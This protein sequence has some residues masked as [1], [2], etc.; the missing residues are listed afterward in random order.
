MP[1][2]VDRYG[3]NAWF[4]TPGR[5]IYKSQERTVTRGPDGRPLKVEETRIRA[6]NKVTVIQQNQRTVGQGATKSSKASETK[7]NGTYTRA[8][9]QIAG[10]SVQVGGKVQEVR[11]QVGTAQTHAYVQG[12]H[13]R[14]SGDAFVDV[15]KDGFEAMLQLDVTANLVTG[16]ASITQDYH[17]KVNGENVTIRATVGADCK[18]G[19]QGRLA[20][21]VMM[22]DGKPGVV[23][24]PKGFVGARCDIS[25]KAQ[26]Y[27]NDPAKPVAEVE[28]A[29][30]FSAGAVA[31]AGLQ[32]RSNGFKAW[33][34]AAVG[35]G[36]GFELKA[37][38][39][40]PRM[41]WE[42]PGLLTNKF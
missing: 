28:S 6:T 39:D 21:G 26:V 41:I 23:F 7:D 31:D 3:S 16:G 25:A 38:L 20:I 29:L 12:P 1:P 27:I 30:V 32:V 14:M 17:M 40:V 11:G 13:L 42:T 35:A 19:A 8:R 4:F 9:G 22:I 24:E 10:G 37:T 18:A 5:S 34:H 33:G 36:A 2:H 15:N